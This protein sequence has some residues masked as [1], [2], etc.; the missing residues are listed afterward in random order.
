M[1]RRRVG[2]YWIGL[3]DWVLRVSLEEEEVF[4]GLEGR[5]V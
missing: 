4:I 2:L 3:K 5:V 1:D